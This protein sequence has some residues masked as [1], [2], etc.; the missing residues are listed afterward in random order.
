MSERHLPVRPNL[1]QLKHQAKDLLREMKHSRPEARLTE[2]QFELARSYGVASW[3]RLVLACRMVDAIWR[4]D[5]SVVRALVTKPR[6]SRLVV[7]S[8]RKPCRHLRAP[9]RRALH[10]A[11]SPEHHVT[12][13]DGSERVGAS[14]TPP[15]RLGKTV[16]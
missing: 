15:S 1:T 16:A 12:R 9:I 14:E 6:F 7:S 4:D 5:V 3:P 11:R 2:A 8:R 13:V 10:D